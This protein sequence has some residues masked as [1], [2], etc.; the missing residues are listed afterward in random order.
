MGDL[1]W[2]RVGYQGILAPLVSELNMHR[3]ANFAGLGHGAWVTSSACTRLP[4]GSIC[5]GVSAIRRLLDHCIDRKVLLGDSC[6]SGTVGVMR[7]N[8]CFRRRTRLSWA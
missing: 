8:G 3:V 4:K 7:L 5:P 6:E 1:A 2:R